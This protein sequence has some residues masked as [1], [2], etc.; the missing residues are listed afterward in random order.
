MI[1]CVTGHRPKGFSFPRDLNNFTYENYYN[2]LYNKVKNLIFEGYDYFIS[3]MAD[4]ADIDFA[5]IVL[6]LKNEG[7]PIMLEAALPYP[8]H[9]SIKKG[10]KYKEELQIL[11]TK[12]DCKT[13]VS[14]YYFKGCMQKRNRYMVDKSDLV[15]AIWNGKEE[16][17]TWDTIK[18]ALSKNKP[19]Q[20]IMLDS[21]KPNSL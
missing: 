3:G 5:S 14:P 9:S 11:L 17:G 1:C 15:L 2:Y 12:C 19:I 20:Y 13:I 6:I 18:Y 10:S 16:G 4:G 7:Y 21:I 8:P